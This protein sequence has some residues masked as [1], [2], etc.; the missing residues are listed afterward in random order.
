MVTD[1]GHTLDHATA[2]LQNGDAEL[3]ARIL[4]PRDAVWDAVSIFAPPPQNPNFGTKKLVVRLSGKVTRTRI[5][6]A[7]K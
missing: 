7:L 5:E 4:S 2:F 3:E 6:I 1:A